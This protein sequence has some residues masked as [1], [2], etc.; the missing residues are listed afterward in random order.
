MASR[1]L[2]FFYLG[3]AYIGLSGWLGGKE[4]TC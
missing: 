4:S 3:A 1:V 2:M